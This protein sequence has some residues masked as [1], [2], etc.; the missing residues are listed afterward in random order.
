MAI[1]QCTLVLQSNYSLKNI[2]QDGQ[3][4][5]LKTTIICC[6]NILNVSV[7]LP[8]GILIHVKIV[9]DK[10]NVNFTNSVLIQQ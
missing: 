5:I 1:A 9:N 10:I 7:I 4:N 3:L 8:I 2:V 6:L